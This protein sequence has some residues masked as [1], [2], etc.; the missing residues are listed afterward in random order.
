[1]A[2]PFTIPPKAPVLW[3]PE[4]KWTHR[5]QLPKSVNFAPVGN[6]LIDFGVA[7]KA[8]DGADT[9]AHAISVDVGP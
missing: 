7:D 9:L 2:E 3:K 8:S 1:M 6:E 5:R 4:G